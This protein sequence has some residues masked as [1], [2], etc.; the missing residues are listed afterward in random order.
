VREII[1]DYTTMTRDDNGVTAMLGNDSFDC[2]KNA[3]VEIFGNF[4]RTETPL[5]LL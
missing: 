3:V 5:S 2:F 4:V 1:V